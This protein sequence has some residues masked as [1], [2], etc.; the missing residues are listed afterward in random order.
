MV[1][2]TN[3]TAASAGANSVEA[4]AKTTKKNEKTKVEFFNNQGVD[5]IRFN[6]L[7]DIMIA[8]YATHEK[9]T[10]A[11]KLQ[12][13]LRTICE[14]INVLN[15]MFVGPEGVKTQYTCC[16]DVFKREEYLA[17]FEGTVFE[18]FIIPGTISLDGTLEEWTINLRRLE[19]KPRKVHKTPGAMG[20]D[21]AKV[22]SFF[23]KLKGERPSEPHIDVLALK[24]VNLADKT[25]CRT[26]STL[27]IILKDFGPSRFESVDR[28]DFETTKFVMRRL[29]LE[30]M[31]KFGN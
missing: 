22:Y 12:G 19:N 9:Q 6:E 13:Y 31:S 2:T 1:E 16:G 30:A 5:I 8:K 26:T 27:P 24:D 21:I 15:D 17:V 4:E 28:R 10:E 14:D 23:R 11:T 18:Q 3:S 7:A 20:A 29:L 25:I